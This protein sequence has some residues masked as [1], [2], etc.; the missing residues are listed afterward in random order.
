MTAEPTPDVSVETLA[1]LHRLARS[2]PRSGR[3]Q[4]A[5]LGAIRTLERLGRGGKLALP[6]PEGWHPAP[7]SDWEALDACDPVERRAHWWRN[8]YERGRR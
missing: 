6:M 4:T 7:G 3:G 1:E 5:K 2:R 8:L